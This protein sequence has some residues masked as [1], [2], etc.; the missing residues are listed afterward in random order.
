MEKDID[1]YCIYCLELALNWLLNQSSSDLPLLCC[2]FPPIKQ[3]CLS[4]IHELCCFA[5]AKPKQMYNSLT[6][7]T[8]ILHYRVYF[9]VCVRQCH[10][11]GSFWG[12]PKVRI[13]YK[14]WSTSGLRRVP[15]Q[16]RTQKCTLEVCQIIVN[17]FLALLQPLQLGGEFSHLIEGQ[18]PQ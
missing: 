9:R 5:A 1:F 10:R 12:I 15:P 6:N 8:L 17:Y 2:H 3:T 13:S 18:L 7:S 4:D 16:L 11:G 14:S